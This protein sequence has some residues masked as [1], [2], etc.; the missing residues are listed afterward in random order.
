MV[1]LA[2]ESVM[3]AN[4]NTTG[5]AFEFVPQALL[6]RMEQLA[7]QQKVFDA[8]E[9]PFDS[10]RW[11]EVGFEIFGLPGAVAGAF[12]AIVSG[13]YYRIIVKSNLESEMLETSEELCRHLQS[14]AVI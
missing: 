10:L 3:D 5:R 6:D 13:G 12:A 7:H 8:K 4:E 14:L 11:A 2:T 9:L 1:R